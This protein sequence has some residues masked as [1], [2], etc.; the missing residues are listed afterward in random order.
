MHDTEGYSRLVAAA[1]AALVELKGYSWLGESRHRLPIGAM[2]YQPEIREFAK[3]IEDST[4]YR[5][6]ADDE[7]SR[8][9]VLAR[10]KATTGLALD[11]Q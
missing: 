7:I 2:P 3:R 11:P 1:S 5:A 8:V 4:G 10:D 6:V 9:V